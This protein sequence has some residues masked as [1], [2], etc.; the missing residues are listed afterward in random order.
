MSDKDNNTE[1]VIQSFK[2]TFETGNLVDVLSQASEVGLDY[3]LDIV[4]SAQILKDIPVLGLIVSGTKTI[5]NIR[6]YLLAKKVFK[7][8]FDIRDI[9]IEK[10]Q[11]FADE[12][13]RENREDTASAL[14]MILDRLNNQNYVSIICRL[15][16]AKMNGHISI[17][18]FNRAV[19]ALERISYTDIYQLSKFVEDYYEEG[20][21]E[22]FESSGLVYQS[23]V[24]GG[25]AASDS[26]SGTKMRLSSTGRILLAYGLN[27]EVGAH[28][29]RSTDVRGGVQW[30]TFGD[31]EGF[32]VKR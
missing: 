13:C 14:L 3:T 16:R 2:N 22:A 21:A 30:E 19:L 18:E 27:I 8:L 15:M 24:G 6:N 9:P 23:V 32:T 28:A 4:D 26:K 10:R 31:V 17:A 12:Y 29:P 5:A 25:N 20:L 1:I 11:K 7:F